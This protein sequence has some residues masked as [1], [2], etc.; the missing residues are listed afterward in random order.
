MYASEGGHGKADEISE[1]ALFYSIDQQPIYARG[2]GQKSQNFA[3]ILYG[4]LL[5]RRRRSDGPKTV[6]QNGQ[7]LNRRAVT[8]DRLE[9]SLCELQPKL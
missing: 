9:G 8:Q 7:V 2:R 3:Y 4:R 5:V 1:V 6:Q